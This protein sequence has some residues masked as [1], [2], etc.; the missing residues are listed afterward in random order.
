MVRSPPL[1]GRLEPWARGALLVPSPL[2][3]SSPSGENRTLLG[4]ASDFSGLGGRC[5]AFRFSSVPQTDRATHGPRRN[6]LACC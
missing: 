1:G 2:A 4:S 6:R 3:G 5:I